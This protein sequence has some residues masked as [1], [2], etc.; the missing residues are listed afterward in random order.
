MIIGQIL[1][2]TFEKNGKKIMICPSY[3]VLV[4]QESRIFLINKSQKLKS[5]P[6]FQMNST[7]IT[8]TDLRR[9]IY[10]IHYEPWHIFANSWSFVL[11]R[12]NSLK[13]SEDIRSKGNRN[14]SFQNKEVVR[15]AK[16]GLLSTY[17]R[18]QLLS[19]LAKG[20]QQ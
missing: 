16:H 13:S 6:L 1:W 9:K 4:N 11:K 7:R 17:K 14:H 8:L 10:A 2:R 20:L 12:V 5:S 18:S 15:S 19:Y 3:L